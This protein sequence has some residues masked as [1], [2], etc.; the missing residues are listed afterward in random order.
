[1]NNR[2][3]FTDRSFEESSLVGVVKNRPTG[4]AVFWLI[5][6]LLMIFEGTL[7]LNKYGFLFVI[8]LI[9]LLCALFIFMKVEQFTAV[10][11][12][13]DKLI[14]TDHKNHDYGI[15]IDYEE[16]KSWEIE[17][18]EGSSL[19]INLKDGNQIN[20]RIT[21]SGKVSALLMK[22]IGKKEKNEKEMEQFRQN[23]DK[24]FVGI[25]DIRKWFDKKDHIY[26]EKH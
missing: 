15:L 1:M 14:L 25:R 7:H 16:I 4:L 11:V 18:S 6:S 26:E 9:N 3:Y 5:F 21:Q 23:N 19:I 24:S 10:R 13:H 8:G 22:T 17:K 2:F 20:Y 12:C